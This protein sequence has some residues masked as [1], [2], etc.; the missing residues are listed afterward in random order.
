MPVKNS[1]V[2]LKLENTPPSVGA[3]ER[4]LAQVLSGELPTGDLPTPHLEI[5][6]PPQPPEDSE[7]VEAVT[8]LRH[9]SINTPTPLTAP[10]RRALPAELSPT[11]AK[12]ATFLNRT[13]TRITIES[14]SA[15]FQ[16]FPIAVLESN[17]HVTLIL[18]KDSGH[19]IPKN[20]ITYVLKL[21]S[22]DVEGMYLGGLIEHEELPFTIL[23][24]LVKDI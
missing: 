9:V 17:T 19:P 15:D 1:P 10:P 11:L 13:P 21:I 5:D 8:G 2:S 23:S 22:G 12:V 16:M 3:R 20:G 24:F 18:T 7:P 14:E 6:I 4:L